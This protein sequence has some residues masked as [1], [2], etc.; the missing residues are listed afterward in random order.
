LFNN[1]N[2]FNFN[3]IERTHLKYTNALD[4]GTSWTFMF[5]L[6][7]DN[8]LEE[9]ML[10]ICN[11]LEKG[12]ID[13]NNIDVYVLLDRSEEFSTKDGNWSNTRLYK[14]KSDTNKKQI[15]STLI[16]DFEEKEMDNPSTLSDFIRYCLENS[17]AD[18][19]FLSLA[20]HGTGIY[21]LCIDDSSNNDDGG[22]LTI[23]ELQQGIY[24]GIAGLEEK[25]DVIYLT[26]CE[27]ACFEVAYELKDFVDYLIALQTNRYGK[28]IDYSKIL[29]FLYQ[30]PNSSSDQLALKI[31]ENYERNW[32]RDFRIL[33]YHTAISLFDLQFLQQ[34]N[35]TFNLFVFEMEKLIHGM[36]IIHLV[37]CRQ[38]TLDFDYKHIDLIH[39]IENLLSNDF[40]LL[41][42]PELILKAQLFY[43]ALHNCLVT[44]YQNSFFCGNANGF[45]IYFPYPIT[46]NENLWLKAYNDITYSFS[47]IDFLTDIN[48]NNFVYNFTNFDFD[49]DSLPNWFEYYYQLGPL[50]PDYNFDGVPDYKEDFDN[51]LQINYWEFCDGTNPLISDTD[52]DGINDREEG[53][54]YR[55]NNPGADVDGYVRTLGFSADSDK[56][57]YTD[58]EEIYFFNTDPGNAD[59][60]PNKF[61]FSGRIVFILFFI[62]FI[63]VVIN[64]WPE[65][66]EDS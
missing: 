27:M 36:D 10:K 19:Y 48:W 39:F 51:D 47:N 25:I 33:N 15:H 21:G 13:E 23:D 20:N 8:N 18:Y 6:D 2:F 37:E 56:D 42:Y 55:P 1:S 57:G 11:D 63:I 26:A 54:I 14:I 31:I 59:S 32:E 64:V 62:P 3:S 41:E 66:K 34:I 43:E 50:V 30:N 58:K 7:G 49:R 65:K 45:S 16:E 35:E 44:N 60:H 52:H 61:L 28:V 24:Q 5:Y 53:R 40:L 29:T 22:I 17:P 38:H 46:Y 12:F 9:Y 4:E